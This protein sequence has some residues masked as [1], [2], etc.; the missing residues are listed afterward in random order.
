MLQRYFVEGATSAQH[1]VSRRDQTGE[2]EQDHGH[3]V[4]PPVDLAVVLVPLNQVFCE[5]HEEH[6]R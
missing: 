3:H 6:Y 5:R 1:V 4:P 2:E